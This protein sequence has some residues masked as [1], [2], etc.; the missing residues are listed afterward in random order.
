MSLAGCHAGLAPGDRSSA[1]TASSGFGMTA[2]ARTVHRSFPTVCRVSYRQPVTHLGYVD[3]GWWPRSW[4]LSAELPAL[5]ESFSTAGRDMT[6]IAYNLDT[7]NLAPRRMIIEGQRI[8]L[9]GY[10]KQSPLLVSISDARH[11]DTA[12]LLVI[13]F[14]TD[15]A[16]AERLLELACEPDNISRPEEMFEAARS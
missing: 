2:L 8:H 9:G 10:H 16:I 3:A 1:V 6:R 5:F 14:D 11:H 4:D 7:W 15:D 13:P 12:D